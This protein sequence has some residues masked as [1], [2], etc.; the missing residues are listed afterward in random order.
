[1][2]RRDVLILEQFSGPSVVM[3]QNFVWCHLPWL[4]VKKVKASMSK[5]DFG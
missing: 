5:H 1:M 3:S 2:E 4:V